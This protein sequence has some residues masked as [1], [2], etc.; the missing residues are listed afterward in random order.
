MS[1]ILKT[2]SPTSILFLSILMT[3]LLVSPLKCLTINIISWDNNAGLSQDYKILRKEL[4]ALGHTIRHIDVNPN[5]AM[6]RTRAT[7]D[8]NLFIEHANSDFFCLAKKNYL[9]PNPEWTEQPDSLISQFDLIL[10]R[11][12]EV[13]RIF[14]SINPNTYYIGFTS[15]DK[16]KKSIPKDFNKFFHLRGVS[17]CKGTSAVLDLWKEHPEY[18][19]LTIIG[20]KMLNPHLNNVEV[21][22]QFLAEK[23]LTQLQ[24]QCGIHLC[25]SETEGFGH[26]ISEA[27]SIGAVVITTDAPPMNEFV[28]DKRCLVKYAKTSKKMRATTYFIDPTELA[29]T[30][31]NLKK[32]SPEELKQIGDA[33]RKFYLQQKQQFQDRLKKLFGTAKG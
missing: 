1:H 16:F 33:N 10:C 28:K 6:P 25:P 17:K 18:P 19:F 3:F 32:L 13:Q 2:N 31:E 27:L 23:K 14:T 9:I 21:L 7:A 5:D 22:S 29:S 8:I 15:M 11:T 30:I 20:R 4:T 26:S 24:N 12:K